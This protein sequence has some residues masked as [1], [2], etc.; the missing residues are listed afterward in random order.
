MANIG[1]DW[2]FSK[3]I[4]ED[5]NTG[6]LR[7]TVISYLNEQWERA[8]RYDDAIKNKIQNSIKQLDDYI[9]FLERKISDVAAAQ[10]LDG[11]AQGKRSTQIEPAAT[12]DKEQKRN[13]TIARARTIWRDHYQQWTASDDIIT[14]LKNLQ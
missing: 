10:F 11:Y 12:P 4:L 8:E 14:P 5:P 2:N 7:E 1:E 3:F 9:S 13:E 6:I